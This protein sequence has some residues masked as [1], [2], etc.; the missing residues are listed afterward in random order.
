MAKSKEQIHI[1]LKYA[2]AFRKLMNEHRL[3]S[4]EGEKGEDI[5]NSFDKLDSIT[6]LRK[7]TLLDIFWGKS[8]PSATSIVL[9]IEALGKTYAE[10]GLVY[11]NIT[12]KEIQ[13]FRRL[14]SR[15]Q[16]KS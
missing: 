8:N 16:K 5:V 2:L 14:I 11:D 1:Q 15:R 9:I 10:F 6:R 7:A 3:K 12:E 13:D 4:L